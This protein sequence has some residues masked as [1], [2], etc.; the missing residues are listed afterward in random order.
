MGDVH[1]ARVKCVINYLPQCQLCATII[2]ISKI[3][4][5][6]HNTEMCMV[7]QLYMRSLLLGMTATLY[8][9]VG[10]SI[11]LNGMLHIMLCIRLVEP[12]NN[13]YKLYIFG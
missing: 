8:T 11:V 5:K 3:H 1:V 12:N 7:L 10:L 13:M 9:V 6:M 4:Y 2:I